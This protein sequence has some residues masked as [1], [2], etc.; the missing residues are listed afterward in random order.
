MNTLRTKLTA[1]LVAA[2]VVMTVAVTALSLLLLSHPP[3]EIMDEANAILVEELADLA[4]AQPPPAGAASPIMPAPAGGRLA[5]IP[6]D[7]INAMLARRGRS[8]RVEVTQVADRP[9]PMMSINIGDGRWLAVPLAAPPRPDGGWVLVGWIVLLTLGSTGLMIFAVRRLTEPLALLERAVEAIGPGGELAP[10]S[11][12]G[13]TEVRAAARAVNTLSSRLKMAMESRIRLVAA[14][15][16]DL[17]TPMTRMRL[18]VEF[19]DEA[20]RDALIADLDELDRIADSAIRLVREEVE[21]AG[22]TLLRFDM[23]VHEVVEELRDIGLAVEFVA[24]VPV[25]VRGRRLAL[26]RAIRNLAINAAT[27]GRAG[28]LRIETEGD[29]AVLVIEDSGP[30]I[31]DALLGQVFEPFFR[32]M[33]SRE[34]QLPGAG[35]GLAIAREITL[36]HG[37]ELTLRNRRGGGLEQRI[38]LAAA[39]LAKEAP[40]GTDA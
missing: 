2:I 35:L 24:G 34:T 22:H 32:G 13:P 29:Q 39:P 40:D 15:G 28:R 14:A 20:E 6:T 27:H 12:E 4:T 25:S 5:R 30:G 1:L 26:K 19:L 23:L 36:N 21:G 3:F 10:L 38:R 11:E 16:H 9:W 17:R 7:G 33:A 8:E 37:G 31:P 18:R